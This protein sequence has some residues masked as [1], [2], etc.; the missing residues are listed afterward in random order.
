MHPI[1]VSVEDLLCAGR[2]FQARQVVRRTGYSRQLV[3]RHL[4]RMVTMGELTVR[5]ERR[6]VY[7][8][9]GPGFPWLLQGVA[10][11]ADPLDLW[12]RMA[13]KFERFAYVRLR[14]LGRR[15]HTRAQ[16]RSAM[17]GLGDKDF[18]VI[19]FA[20][21]DSASEAFA[22]EVFVEHVYR[23]RHPPMPINMSAGVEVVVERMR[24]FE[25]RRDRADQQIRVDPIDGR[26]VGPFVLAADED[27]PEADGTARDE[28]AQP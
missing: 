9:A 4:R 7:Y 3:N 5:G 20:Q 12:E 15:M 11:G 24:R 14:S 19:D 26:I 8:S 25:Q 13:A 6:G 10:R 23:Y 18:V 17:D 22:H 28:D 27:S 1:R 16:A 21:V 2:S